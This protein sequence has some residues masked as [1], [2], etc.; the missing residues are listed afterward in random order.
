MSVSQRDRRSGKRSNN[1]RRIGTTASSK[2]LRLPPS[3]RFGDTNTHTHATVSCDRIMRRSNLRGMSLL[4]LIT[5]FAIVGVLIA[6]LMVGIHSARTSASRLSCISNLQQLATAVMQY[7]STH[8]VLPAGN[9]YYGSLHVSLLPFIEQHSVYADIVDHKTKLG[10]LSTMQPPPISVFLCP[11]DR[12]DSPRAGTNYAGCA[13]VWWTQPAGLD[14]VFRYWEPFGNEE[15]GQVSIRDITDGLSDTI[16]LCEV[17]RSDSNSHRLRTNWNTPKSYVDLDT[18]SYQCSQ[19]PNT[20]QALGWKG[21]GCRG[22]P[23]TNGNL[24][25]TLYNHVL[26][27]NNPSCY[28]GSEV[29]SMASTAASGHAGGVNAVFLD[30]HATFVASAIDLRAWRAFASRSTGH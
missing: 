18:L 25:V 16:A 7:E 5:V 29:Q 8:R 10:S 9:S 22:T 21:I 3:E 1:S 11:A 13:G 2:E 6:L 26:P 4:E 19:V 15:A 27:P 20:P 23:W 28:N 12:A 17:L 30:G 24:G 14:G